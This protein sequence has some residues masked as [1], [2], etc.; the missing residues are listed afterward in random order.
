MNSITDKKKSLLCYLNAPYLGGA[1]R[2]FI[3]QAS[4]LDKENLHD[5]KFVVP[6]FN[7]PGEDKKMCDFLNQNG[8]SH[9][10]IH[11]YQYDSKLFSFGRSSFE[12]NKLLSLVQ[13][14]LFIL[15]FIRTVKK[16]QN[17]SIEDGD[18]LWIGGN[19]VG[20][21]VLVLAFLQSFKGRILWHF[22]D[23]PSFLGL[24]KNFWGVYSRLS[25]CRID[26]VGNSFDVADSIKK[27][28]PST[29]VVHTLYNPIGE[30]R[31]KMNEGHRDLILSTASMFAP[32]KGIHFLI[33]FA[34]LYEEKLL[35]IGY[36]KFHIYGDEI[37]KT[38]GDHSGYKDQLFTLLQ[39]FPSRL[40]EFKGMAPPTDIFTSSDVFIHGSLRPEPFGRVL[41]EAYK[42]GAALV[43]TGLG[44]AGELIDDFETGR[45]FI[46]YD[47]EG[48]FECLEELASDNRYSYLEKGRLKGE[49]V[50]KS[51]KRQLLSIF[52]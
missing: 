31:F 2:S 20:P 9:Q 22:R 8:F 6:F 17:I 46:P 16:I 28:A 7:R 14:P 33:H 43:S 37:Y 34:S 23:Y 29:S 15:G 52:K 44:G 51:Y 39:K 42:G 13:I 25:S 40:V 19:K 38:S 3:L 4:D 5:I 27:I 30:L 50:Y 1:E 47:Y 41:I 11:Y 12:K 10:R 36:K 32:W 26:F 24:F 45:V 18:I 21:I 48:L 49:E 35:K